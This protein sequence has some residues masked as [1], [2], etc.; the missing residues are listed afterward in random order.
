MLIG[1]VAALALGSGQARNP[2]PTILSD[3]IVN[4]PPNEA[5]ALGFIDRGSRIR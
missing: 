4:A 1:L 2:E 5:R 3:I